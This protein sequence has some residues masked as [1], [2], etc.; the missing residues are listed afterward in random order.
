MKP[1]ATRQMA[2]VFDVLAAAHDHPTAEALFARVRRRVPRVSL[3]TI[4]RNLD[5]LREQ[6]RLRVLRLDGG[7]AHFDART[8]PHDH[9]VC[10]ACGAVRDLPGGESAPADDGRASGCLVRWRTTAFYGLCGDCAVAERGR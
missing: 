5:K 6:G 8:D 7:E 1:R 3:G 4:Y 10:E 2:A 9:F